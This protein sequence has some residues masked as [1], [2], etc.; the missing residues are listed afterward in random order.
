MTNL[1]TLLTDHVNGATFIGID[2]ETNVKLTGGKANPLQGR[3]TKRV[4]GSNVMVFQNKKSSGYEAMVMRRLEKEGKD[5][6]TFALSPRAWGTRLSGAPLVE[7]KGSYYVEVIFLKP[8]T[9]EYLVDGHVT[10]KEDITGLTERTHADEA[11]QGGLNDKVII[12]TYKA[13]SIK[14]IVIDGER[15]DDLTFNLPH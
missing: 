11:T 2:T 10:A 7:H 5:P 14:S 1:A 12:R 3:V 4:R 13:D 15:Y 8:G 6:S 9:T